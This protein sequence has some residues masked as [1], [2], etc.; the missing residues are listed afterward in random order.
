VSD[1]SKVLCEK[2]KLPTLWLDTSVVI[3]QTILFHCA[4]GSTVG[5]Y[6]AAQARKSGQGGNL[7]E[8]K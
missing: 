2:P 4:S 8:K 7:V 6:L 5:T 3:K 1:N